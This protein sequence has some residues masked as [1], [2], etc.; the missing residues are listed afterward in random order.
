V[1]TLWIVDY[2][3]DSKEPAIGR[4]QLGRFRVLNSSC[5]FWMPRQSARLPIVRDTDRD[6][7]PKSDP[8][9]RARDRVYTRVFHDRFLAIAGMNPLV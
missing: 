5:A 1:V 7:H 4:M 6:P 8:S 9:L 2:A 3:E